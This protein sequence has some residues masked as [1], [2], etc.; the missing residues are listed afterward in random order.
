LRNA[1]G[2]IKEKEVEDQE[3]RDGRRKLELKTKINP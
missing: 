2:F 1:Y 3:L